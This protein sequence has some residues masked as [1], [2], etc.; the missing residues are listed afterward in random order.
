MELIGD[1]DMKII[2]HERKANIIVADLLSKKS[3]HSLCTALSLIQLKDKVTKMGIHMIHK[4]DAVG[5]LTA[6]PEFYDDLRQ[7]QLL[8]PKIQEWRGRVANNNMSRF[9]IHVDGIV[10]Y[11]GRWCVSGDV[12]MRKAIMTE[13][14]CTPYSVHP[15]G[16]NLYKDLKK[17]FWWP[18][19]KK[20]V[21]EFVARYTWSKLQ[22]ANG[23]RKNVVRLHGVPK[24]I[25]SDRDASTYLYRNTERDLG[26]KSAQDKEQRNCVT[27]LKVLWSNH[28]VEEAT[29]EV[30]E[31]MKERYPHLFEQVEK[32]SNQE[33]TIQGS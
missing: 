16:D 21:A 13:A 3:V 23:Y 2:Y 22:L 9:S 5:D 30:E 12:E 11:D 25:V 18:R 28:N 26:S 6:E 19:M 27:L 24:D 29:W 31:A 8:D 14:H 10:R 17:T 33:D 4:R 32:L 1:Y 7:K 20:D 15:G